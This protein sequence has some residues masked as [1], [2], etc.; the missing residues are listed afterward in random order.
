MRPATVITE[1]YPPLSGRM[2]VT[3]HYPTIF[4]RFIPALTAF[5][6]IFVLAACETNDE[7]IEAHE[8]GQTT[9]SQNAE[10]TT[11]EPAATEAEMQDGVQHARIN[12]TDQGFS[13]SSISLQEGVPARLTFHQQSQSTC[14]EYVQIPAFGVESTQLPYGEETTIEF[15]PDEAGQFTFVCGMD[16]LSGTLVVRS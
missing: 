9:E 13:P 4:M 12:V 16:M 11:T 3:S 10:V 8:Q 15:T 5:A 2:P 6:L 14:A 1:A 7:H